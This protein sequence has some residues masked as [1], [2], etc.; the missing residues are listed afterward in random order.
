VQTNQP[1]V[2]F[3]ENSGMASVVPIDKV[4]DTIGIVESKRVTVPAA[5]PQGATGPG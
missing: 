3:E 5:K 4:L 2:I 1:R